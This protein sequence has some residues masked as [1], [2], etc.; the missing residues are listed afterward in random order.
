[1]FLKPRKPSYY[2]RL[3]R[4]AASRDPG[5]PVA[6]RTA[7]HLDP[8]QNRLPEI[9][10][11]FRVFNSWKLIPIDLPEIN[12]KNRPRPQSP[13]QICIPTTT[14]GSNPP[15]PDSSL[16]TPPI[17]SS[18]LLTT[19]ETDSLLSLLPHPSITVFPTKQPPLSSS[20]PPL[21]APPPPA[22]SP[23]PKTPP[24]NLS[25]LP[26]P[27]PKKSSPPPETS[28]DPL[29]ELFPNYLS[30][31]KSPTN[32]AEFEELFNQL[33][34]VVEGPGVP[35]PEYVPTRIST[36]PKRPATGQ[37]GEIINSPPKKNPRIG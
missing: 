24:K 33:A 25:P 17:T 18:S 20:P 29:Q 8:R 31:R 35:P 13:L 22:V 14:T 2:R 6:T 37:R 27:P 36:R 26:N 19:P 32:D 23:L 11:E 9:A 21:I 1:M 12:L 7:N 34:A 16:Q 15:T 30:G 4:R 5:P 3:L 10:P 28:R